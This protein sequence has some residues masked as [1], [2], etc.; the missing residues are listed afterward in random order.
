MVLC[1][2]LNPRTIHALR[3]EG[4]LYNVPQPKKAGVALRECGVWFRDRT[5]G[6]DFIKRL[7]PEVK[8]GV[9]NARYLRAA[10]I[11]DSMFG[12]LHA[13]AVMQARRGDGRW[14][15]TRMAE[16]WR[17]EGLPNLSEFIQN[18]RE[19][20]PVIVGGDLNVEDKG[21]ASAAH[22]FRE[23]DME[24]FAREVMWIAW[25][26]EYRKVAANQRPKVPGADAHPVVRVVLQ[27][28]DAA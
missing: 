3:Q 27:R 23:H 1:S 19:H 20:G 5:A 24:F 16:V 7:T 25:T 2:E 8:K 11:D 18:Q 4:V 6:L 21:E 22:F 28:K 10:R 26:H 12:A 13:N 15:D 14:K 9:G 17:N